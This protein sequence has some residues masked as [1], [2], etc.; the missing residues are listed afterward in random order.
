MLSGRSQG[1]GVIRP[2]ADSTAIIAQ[3]SL[4]SVTAHSRPPM[5]RRSGRTAQLGADSRLHVRIALGR[6]REL[7]DLAANTGNTRA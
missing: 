4:C 5:N 6:S 3:L 1:L 7:V 2:H